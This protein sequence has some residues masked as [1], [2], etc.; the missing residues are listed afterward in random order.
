MLS[1]SQTSILPGRGVANPTDPVLEGTNSSIALS[2]CLVSSVC[3]TS[4]DVADILDSFASFVAFAR[5]CAGV[6]RLNKLPPPKEL[7]DPVLA[8]AGGTTA[9]TGE[10]SV[11]ALPGSI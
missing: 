10:Y 6:G 8:G 2:G 1:E 3:K 5:S 11:E 7:A 9:L 4:Y